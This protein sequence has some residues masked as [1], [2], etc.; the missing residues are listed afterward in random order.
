MNRNEVKILSK[1]SVCQIKND[2]SV[3]KNVFLKI[4]PGQVSEIH[5]MFIIYIFYVHYIQFRFRAWK[6]DNL[7]RYRRVCVHIA[8]ALKN[9]TST[10]EC[11]TF[12]IFCGDLCSNFQ[13]RFVP[14]K[15]I[16]TRRI[17][18]STTSNKIYNI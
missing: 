6:R 4:V 14:R 9:S 11:A 3:M 5:L 13:Y 15:S 2:S 1:T 12:A 8:T 7:A 10:N 17:K 16:S 18:N